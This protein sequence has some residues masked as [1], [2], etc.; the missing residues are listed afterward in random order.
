M[1]KKEG[2][3]T[4]INKFKHKNVAVHGECSKCGAYYS[5]KIHVGPLRLDFPS[6]A[7]EPVATHFIILC[8]KCRRLVNLVST[9]KKP[10][11]HK[12]SV[13]ET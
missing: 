11:K 4:S 12:V 8:W 13:G 2:R 7:T 9:N 10:L 1:T 5:G 3:I 6:D